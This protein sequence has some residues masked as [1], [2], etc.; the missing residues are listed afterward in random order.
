MSRNPFTPPFEALPDTLPVFPL[1]GAILMPG[2]ELPLNIFEPRYLQMVDDALGGHRLIG[3][4]QPGSEAAG[5]ALCKVG[6]AGR[7]TSFRETDDGR[8]ELSLSGV[9]R[10]DLDEELATTRG[11][12]LIVPDWTRF[13]SDYADDNNLLEDRRPHLLAALRRFFDLKGFETDMKRLESMPAARLVDSLIMALPLA[14]T[15]KQQLLETIDMRERLE[16]FIAF[17]DGDD[18]IPDSITRH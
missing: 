12:R 18:K 11:Y 15:E 16:R 14:E 5:D 13:A 6:C 17:I 7:I 2:A 9:C 3:M 1:P 10:F 4:I 8:I